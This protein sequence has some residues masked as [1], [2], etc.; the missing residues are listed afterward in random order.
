MQPQYRARLTNSKP[1]PCK[2]CRYCAKRRYQ[3]CWQKAA[4]NYHCIY[5]DPQYPPRTR[6][7]LTCKNAEKP[8]QLY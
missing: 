1:T 5:G 4:S 2:E 3:T 8:L 6:K 7:H